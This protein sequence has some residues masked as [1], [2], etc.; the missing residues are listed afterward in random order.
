MMVP[1]TFVAMLALAGGLGTGCYSELPPPAG[2]RYACEA[3]GDCNDNEVCRR[4]VCE[5]PCTQATA[6][7]DC[8]TTDGYATCFNG[9]CANTCEVGADRCPSTHECID[10]G[11]NLGGGGNPF[12]G[13]GSDAVIGICGIECDADANADICPQG[14]VCFAEL[15]TCVVDCSQ[16]QACPTGF[17]CLFGVCAPSSGDLP[18][19]G[20]D[21]GGGSTSGNG[22]TGGG[23]G[24]DG[25]GSG[26]IEPGH[27]QELQR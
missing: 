16:G 20:D 26:A 1:R 23:D 10:L 27:Q 5:R 6:A 12:G 22:S 9:A 24:S 13:G 3:D 17:D 18:P 21:D 7:E 4:G 8:P 14:E 15:G 2:Y 11:L 25:S 19:A